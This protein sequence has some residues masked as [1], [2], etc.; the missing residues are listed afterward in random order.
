MADPA[1]IAV[2]AAGTAVGAPVR[3]LTDRFIQTR[4]DQLFPWGTFTV[5]ITGSMILGVL[6]AL[7]VRGGLGPVW[8]LLLGTGFCGGLTTFSTFGYET[9]GLAEDGVVGAALLNVVGSIVVG[10]IAAACG[11]GIGFWLSG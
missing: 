4:H 6:T 3:Y 7:A 10:L 11:L 2:V 1:S 5:N 8:L 9:L